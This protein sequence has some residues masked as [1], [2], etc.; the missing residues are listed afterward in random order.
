M[1]LSALV[2]RRHTDQRSPAS[3]ISIALSVNSIRFATAFRVIA[4]RQDRDVFADVADV[5]QPGIV[6]QNT[7]AGRN[8]RFSGPRRDVCVSAARP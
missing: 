4:G 7:A 2:G 8:G 3:A 5:E 6:A 1:L